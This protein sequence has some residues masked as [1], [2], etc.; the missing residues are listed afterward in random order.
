MKSRI[1]LFLVVFYALAGLL[2]GQTA[3]PAS[4]PPQASPAQ[5]A[6]AQNPTAQ[7]PPVK[8]SAP[9]DG[10]TPAGQ[11][12]APADNSA[13]SDSDDNITIRHSVNEVRV[14]F[15]VTD[16]HGHYIKDLQRDDFKVIDD[17]KPAGLDQLPKRDRSAA[18]GRAAG[19][20]E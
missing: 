20:R 1:F 10:K 6:P 18:A 7:N 15:T 5:S 13:K 9:P 14:V 16:R 19:G 17:Q 4:V 2:I 12:P 8:T 11:A 3:T